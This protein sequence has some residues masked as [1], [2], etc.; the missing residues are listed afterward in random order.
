MHISPVDALA[1]LALRDFVG[2]DLSRESVPDA[3]TLLK[4][5]RLLEEHGLT[6]KLF[7]GI[8]ADLVECGLL[9]R[10]GTMV[11]ATIIAAPPSTK[12]KD[13]AR[14]PEMHQTKT[15]RG[16]DSQRHRME[17]D[18]AEQHDHQDGRGH[19]QDAHEGARVREGAE[20]APTHLASRNSSH[21]QRA[22]S[23]RAELFSVE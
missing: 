15:G 2:I 10:E 7:E 4:F 11:D 18:P 17:R 1:L 13:K 22:A 8:N 6:V 23:L 5:R 20:L 3:T 14:D 12:N 16:Q 9:L 19:P 21:S